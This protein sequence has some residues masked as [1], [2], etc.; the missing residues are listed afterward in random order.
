MAS[1]SPSPIQEFRY[2]KKHAVQKKMTT[3]FGSYWT[4]DQILIV[5]RKVVLLLVDLLGEE[6]TWDEVIGGVAF[7]IVRGF[8]GRVNAAAVL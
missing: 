6:M 1:A 5:Q 7:V 2:I 3:Q 8:E 4:C